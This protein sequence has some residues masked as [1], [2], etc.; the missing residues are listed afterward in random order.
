LKAAWCCA[1]FYVQLFA[2]RGFRAGVGLQRQ[3]SLPLKKFVCSVW[4]GVK[5]PATKCL[6]GKIVL[7]VSRHINVKMLY[8]VEPPC[9]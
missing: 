1:N 5:I 7:P 9:P 8:P 3:S 2:Q 6:Y 4:G